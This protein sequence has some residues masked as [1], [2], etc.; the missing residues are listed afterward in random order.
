MIEDGYIQL[1]P[2]DESDSKSPATD[3][4]HPSTK[5]SNSSPLPPTKIDRASATDKSPESPP[6][7]A[8]PP[9]PQPPP[10][11][12]HPEPVAH[13]HLINPPNRRRRQRIHRR[14]SHPQQRPQKIQLHGKINHLIRFAAVTRLVN[15]R[16]ARRQI[17][18]NFTPR[19][20]V[21]VQPFG[22]SLE[23]HNRHSKLGFEHRKNLRLFLPQ[24]FQR[25]TQSASSVH[26]VDR[27][28]R[29]IINHAVNLIF[30][31]FILG[32]HPTPKRRH[33]GKTQVFRFQTLSQKLRSCRLDYLSNAIGMAF[34]C[35]KLG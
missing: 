4:N 33:H 5:H 7:S 10:P 31:L 11:L 3:R 24:L 6:P 1:F 28:S 2:T 34:F 8:H 29:G 12:P 18:I 35:S 9:A 25:Q 32:L 13:P 30:R 19:W 20:A 22:R 26:G 14:I 23:P 27:A 15:L 17:L 16:R 21:A